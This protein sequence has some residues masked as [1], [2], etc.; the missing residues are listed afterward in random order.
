LKP[1]TLIVMFMAFANRLKFRELFLLILA[2]FLLD[3]VIPDMI[4][5]IDEII[6]GLLTLLLASLKKEPGTNDGQQPAGNIIEGEVIRENE[7]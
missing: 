3:L 6:L 4:P 7:K 2:L 5:L 1:D